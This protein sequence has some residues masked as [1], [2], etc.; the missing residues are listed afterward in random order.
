MYG[1]LRDW[2]ELQEDP[3]GSIVDD[4]CGILFVVWLWMVIM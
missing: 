2:W 3:W 4:V 1:K